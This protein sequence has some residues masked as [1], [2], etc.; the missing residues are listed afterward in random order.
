[1]S[2]SL[3]IR[4]LNLEDYLFT[5]RLRNDPNVLQWFHSGVGTTHLRHFIWFAKRFL[6]RRNATL[7]A[8][9]D[10]QPAGICYLSDD[11]IKGVCF[12]SI[13]VSISFR[14]IGVGK[15]LLVHAIEVAKGI[16]IKE[17]KAS[18]H[19]NNLASLSLFEQ[20]GFIRTTNTAQLVDFILMEKTL[21]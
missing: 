20:L 4:L 16:G 21:N 13:N 12:L 18:I 3:Y 19:K 1:M 14:R 5:F 11:S 10:N 9:I 6:C 7:I 8:C 2:S 15:Q 17:L